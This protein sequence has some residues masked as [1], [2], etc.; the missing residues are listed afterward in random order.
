[1]KQWKAHKALCEII[2]NNKK[3][4]E[5]RNEQYKAMQKNTEQKTLIQDITHN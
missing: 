1:M 5:Q 4:D 2:S 3:D